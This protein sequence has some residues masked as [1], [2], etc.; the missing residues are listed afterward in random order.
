MAA[1]NGSNSVKIET[2]QQISS[3]TRCETCIH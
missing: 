3:G 1:K 2:K